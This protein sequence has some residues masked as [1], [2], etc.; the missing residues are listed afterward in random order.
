MTPLQ[1][2]ILTLM[3]IYQL[4]Q[5]LLRRETHK[6]RVRLTGNIISLPFIFKGK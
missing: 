2:L 5:K 6:Q 4:V 1:L 3:K